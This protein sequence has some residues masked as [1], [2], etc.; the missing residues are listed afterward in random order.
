MCLLGRTVNS[1]KTLF[2]QSLINQKCRLKSAVDGKFGTL[3]LCWILFDV[4]CNARSV[5][6]MSKAVTV[7][8]IFIS[9]KDKATICTHI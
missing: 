5:E 1:C 7:T 8:V 9:F 3:F 6:K 2:Y 4:L